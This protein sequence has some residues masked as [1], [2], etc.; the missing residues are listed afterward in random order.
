MRRDVFLKCVHKCIRILCARENKIIIN[1]AKHLY[2]CSII[3]IYIINA[4]IIMYSFTILNYNIFTSIEKKIN[5]G[6]QMRKIIIIF[7]FIL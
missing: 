2:I 4:R 5:L 1:P 3:S 6:Q 7:F